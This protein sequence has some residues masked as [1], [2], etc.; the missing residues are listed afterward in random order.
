MSLTSTT[1]PGIHRAGVDATA[2]VASTV[3]AAFFDDPV[4][5]WLLP[6]ERTRQALVQP[7]F[8]LYVAPYIRLG[9]TYLTEDRAGAAVWAPPGSELF[10]AAGA[11]AFGSA[12][13]DL[14]GPGAERFAE[15]AEIFE[16]HHPAEP[17]YYCQ[18][19]ATV[20]QSQGR[21]LGSA[22]LRDMLARADRDQIPAYHEAT[23]PRNRVLY[24]RHG[25]ETV[26][27]FTL[28]DG[29]TL[30]P[31]WREPAPATES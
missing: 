11:E 5:I 19:L 2:A 3:A 25:Y 20:P 28:P 23:T 9:E 13:G 31:M 27:E 8:E 17:S 26:G 12:L 21:G 24:E 16:Q 29:P 30:W 14:V 22:F 1:T 7:L 10:D 6:D 15:L 4:T 18:F